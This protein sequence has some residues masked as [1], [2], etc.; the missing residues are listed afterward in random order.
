MSGD[1]AAFN[2]DLLLLNDDEA[3]NLAPIASMDSLEGATKN[4]HPSGLFSP[5]IF[6]KVGTEYRNRRFAYIN[7]KVDILHPTVFYAVLQLKR[8]YGEIISGSSYAVW[9]EETNDFVKSNFMEGDTGYAFFMEHLPKIAF[10][11]NN[12]VSRSFN[13]D[14]VKKYMDQ[15]FL[16][17]YI[18]IPAGIRDFE[19][20]KEGKPSEDEINTLYRKVLAVSNMVPGSVNPDFINTLDGIRYN[21]QL[22][23][24]NVY[25]YL[26]N[27]VEG[28]RKLTLGKWASRNVYNGTRNVIT[29]MAVN[30][31][32]PNDPRSVKDNETVVGLYQF[33]KSVLP[34]SIFNLRNGFLSNVFPG[35]D[36]PAVLTN[37]KTLHK[38]QITVP[39]ELFD[40]WM[41]EEGVEKILTQFSVE[42]LRH[43]VIKHEGYYFGLIYNDGKYFKLLQDINELPEGFDRSK[44]KPL[45]LTELLYVSV[46]EVSKTIPAFITRYPITGLGS[47]YPSMTH[48]KTTIPDLVLEELNETW[49]PSG[50]I[51]PHFPIPE[52]PFF[53][54]MAPSGSH[55]GRL[56]GDKKTIK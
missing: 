40:N 53:N 51:A 9:N 8:F 48:L 26:K 22:A 50:K 33:M 32:H 21:L 17:R 2:I 1:L 49:Q 34:V 47:I 10:V 37:P 56:G 25:D 35:P 29:G 43:T 28:K 19:Y 18:V 24:N 46:Y 38:E 13:I 16:K 52:K 41:S 36:V 3:K 31:S 23:V 42:D 54:S 20:D 15:C 12:S 39:S 27:L 44:V 4:F 11:K 30:V 6:G 45:T 7:L 5:E 14:L 55:L